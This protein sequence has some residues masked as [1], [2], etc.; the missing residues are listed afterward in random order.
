MVSGTMI[1]CFNI[2]QPGAT[3]RKGAYYVERQNSE[4]SYYADDEDGTHKKYTRRGKF[5]GKKL[6]I[7]L[8][9]ISIC[10]V[11]GMLLTE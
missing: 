11:I 3:T 7:S 8:N 6:N 5:Y 4:I 2:M 1:F 10:Y 9:I